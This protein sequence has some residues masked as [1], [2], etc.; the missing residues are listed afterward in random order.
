M[1]GLSNDYDEIM[2]PYDN[3]FYDKWNKTNYFKKLAIWPYELIVNLLNTKNKPLG[4]LMQL[5]YF[6]AIYCE[7][8]DYFVH[9]QNGF[10]DGLVM[11]FFNLIVGGLFFLVCV[12]KMNWLCLPLNKYIRRD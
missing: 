9:M 5:V 11:Y 3:G 2:H 8:Q 4:Y 12:W 7:I 6:I 1:L 10:M